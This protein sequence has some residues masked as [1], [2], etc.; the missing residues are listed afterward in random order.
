MSLTIFDDTIL[1]LPKEKYFGSATGTFLN[2]NTFATY[3]S[4]GGVVALSLLVRPIESKKRSSGSGGFQSMISIRLPK[5][6]YMIGLAFIVITLFA[7]QSRM[8][9][10]SGMVGMATVLMLRLSQL[11]NVRFIFLVGCVV[12]VLMLFVFGTDLLTVL[13]TS[14]NH[15]N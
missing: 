9:V 12:L 8:G 5:I 11:A 13:S 3:L 2:R 4:L 6:W 1:F 15:L 7:T 10:L 14:C